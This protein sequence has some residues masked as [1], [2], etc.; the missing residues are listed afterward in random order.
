MKNTKLV[1]VGVAILAILFGVI[2]FDK[3]QKIVNVN[4]S[5]KN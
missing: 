2:L 3:Y 4:Q 1:L 5:T